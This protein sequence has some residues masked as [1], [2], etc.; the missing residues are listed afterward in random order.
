MK[1]EQRATSR[2]AIPETRLSVVDVESGVEF[3]AT[4]ADL[5]HTGLKFRS[6]LEP[7]AGA[8]LHVTLTG[9]RG[10]RATLHV[11]RVT[12]CAEGYEVAGRLTRVR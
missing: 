7:V 4:G 8:D 1:T 3:D 5:S 11:T 2:Q 12:T 6:A 10:L 9:E